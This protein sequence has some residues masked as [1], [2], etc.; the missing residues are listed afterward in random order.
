M[1]PSRECKEAAS[2][3]KEYRG[4][5]VAF[6]GAGASAEAGIPTFRGKDGLWNRYRPEELA[7]PYAFATNPRRVWEWYKWRMSI[8]A[9]AQP[10]M[11]HKVLANWER[12][13]ILM[14]VVT[15]NVDGLHQRAGSF[16]VIELHGSIWRVRC[17][18]CGIRRDLGFGNIPKED[19]PRCDECGNILRPDV[20]WFQEPV[21]LDQFQRAEELFSEAKVILVIG[22]SGVVMPAALLP[23]N[24][25]REGKILIEVNPEETNL[26]DLARVRIREP[27]GKAFEHLARLVEEDLT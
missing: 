14:G 13:G 7:T 9:K 6:T 17:T 21:P 12:D 10:T 8:I 4:S 24:A 2:L 1:K 11:A 27:A 19:I 16:K 26:S 25:A 18:S 23:I 20:V 5:I 15:Q 3:I 22:T